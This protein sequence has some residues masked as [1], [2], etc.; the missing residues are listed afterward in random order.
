MAE[1]ILI[2]DDDLDTLRLVGLLLQRKGYQIVAADNGLQALEKAQAET[3][4]LVLLDVMMPDMDGVEVLRRLR[5]NPAT[6]A[7]PIIMFTAKTQVEDKVTGFEAGADDYLTKP[8]HPAE[9]TARVR[10][11]LARSAGKKSA[12]KA[13]APKKDKG[14]VIGVLAAKGGVGVTTVALNMGVM[15]RKTSGKSVTVAEFRPGLGTMGLLLGEKEPDGV[16]ALLRKDASAISD[17]DVSGALA[18]HDSGVKFLFSSFQPADARYLASGEQMAAIA[19]RLGY[20][21]AFTVIDLGTGLPPAV[22]K[23]VEKCDQIVVV[24]EPVGATI[25]QT[26]ALL[27]ELSMK[28]LGL[29]SLQ[30]VEVNRYTSSET[31]NMREIQNALGYNVGM[32]I[33][34][35]ADL[36]L[37][38]ARQ[39]V[40]AATAQQDS[41]IAQQFKKLAELVAAG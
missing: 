37:Q 14:R 24:I 18:E 36:T 7:V 39:G 28:V 41:L 3:P 23:A 21:S 16:S 10:T 15:L 29:S 34:P 2:V 32:T 30:I 33:S 35:A 38:A 25:K 4:D 13:A 9:L 5:A 1:K 12:D 31:L 22:E 20:L 11:I 26:K 27:D 40:P 19:D 6:A 8:T 17:S